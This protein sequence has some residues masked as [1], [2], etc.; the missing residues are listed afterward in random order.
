MKS[1]WLFVVIA[2]IAFA[3]ALTFAKTIPIRQDVWNPTILAGPLTVCS[4]NYINAGTT[5]QSAQCQD[6]CDLFGQIIA[7]IYYIMAVGI[8]IIIPVMVL[9]AGI[10]LMMSRGDPA[11]T[12]EARKMVTGAMWGVGIMLVAYL[13]V[14]SFIGFLKLTDVVGGFG[15]SACT[16]L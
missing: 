16:I 1:R 12:S 7:I 14:S 10:K 15:T 5:Y 3:P 4:G 8:W 9:W 6:L 13:L 11:K 2:F